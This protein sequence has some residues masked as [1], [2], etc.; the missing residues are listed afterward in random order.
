MISILDMKKL[1]K[2][3]M[4]LEKVSLEAV[5]NVDVVNDS[6][7]SLSL[8]GNSNPPE[9]FSHLI[10]LFKGLK[11]LEV[12]SNSALTPY[13][14]HFN[15]IPIE[16][17]TFTHCLVDHHRFLHLPS[18]KHLSLHDASNFTNEDWNHLATL[19][20][21]IEMLNVKDESICN[22]KFTTITQ[23]MLKLRH[24]ELFFDPQRLTSDIL[25]FIAGDHFPLNIKILKIC[26]RNPSSERIFQLTSFQKEMLNLRHG[27]QLY[28][29]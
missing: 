3:S 27:F 24:F 12:E 1:K 10:A 21:K 23:S 20:P 25:N 26:E 13:D 5:R 14:M 29:G 19:N 28:L 7:N 6:V 18:L 22:E 4:N 15:S 2:L 16:S 9:V 11:K 17:L 8:V